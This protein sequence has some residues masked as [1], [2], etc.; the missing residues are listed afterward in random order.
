MA[1]GIQEPHLSIKSEE[2]MEMGVRRLLLPLRPDETGVEKGDGTVHIV[3][4]LP[5][6]VLAG[7]NT[8]FI[9]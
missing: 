9:K 7:I 8:G 6:L 3:L 1:P 2:C 4:H 5:H